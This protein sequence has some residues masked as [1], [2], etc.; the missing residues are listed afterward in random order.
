MIPNKL[1]KEIL[2]DPYYKKCARHKDGNCG[3]RIT[4]EHCLIFGGK[5]IQELW[6]II[7]LCE[8]HH[9]VL[10]YQDKGDLNKEKNVWLALNRATDEQLEKYSRAIDYKQL[11]IRLNKK[12]AK[13]K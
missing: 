7:P 9:N 8:Y 3:G 4:F 6:A 12:Y 13:K 10:S 2:A 5:Q 11:K 1:L